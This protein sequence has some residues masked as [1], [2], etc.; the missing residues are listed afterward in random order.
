[1]TFSASC[2]CGNINVTF[3]ASI[4]S[5]TS[6]NCSIC[7]R[8]GALWGYTHPN[9]VSVSFHR[10]API[11]YCHGDQ[12]IEFHHC[13][14]CGCT[15]HYTPTHMGNTQRMA[16]NFKMIKPELLKQIRIR[17]FDGANTWQFIDE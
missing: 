17:H 3:D 15:T 9:N 13:A 14:L 2:H 12:C 6:C 8:L 5:L 11:S 1:M 7:H 16:M 10:S 4:D